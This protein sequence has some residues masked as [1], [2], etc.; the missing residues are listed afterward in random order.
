[1]KHSKGLIMGKFM[2][3]HKG[4]MAM[5]DFALSQVDNLTI[6]VVA[7]ATD[8]IHG[9]KRLNWIRE[10][11]ED[12][13]RIKVEL[14]ENTLPHDGAYREEDVLEWCEYIKKRFPDIKAFISSESYGDILAD[15][16]HIEHV[17]YDTKR[18]HKP[19]SSTMIRKDPQ[20]HQHHLP[21]HVVRDYVKGK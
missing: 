19:I 3:L 10:M 5:I 17:V 13:N 11:Y 8:Q 7:N 9:L 6:L 14:M 12:N 4:H 18:V 15:Y 16:M 2:P 20:K 1:M 21:E